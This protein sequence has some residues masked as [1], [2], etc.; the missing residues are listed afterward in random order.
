MRFDQWVIIHSITPVLLDNRNQLHVFEEPMVPLKLTDWISISSMIRWSFVMQELPNWRK[1]FHEYK[2]NAAHQFM[3]A[4]YCWIYGVKFCLSA[5][6]CRLMSLEKRQGCLSVRTEGTR[7]QRC[8]YDQ[9]PIVPPCKWNSTEF[10]ENF[11]FQLC[12]NSISGQ[13]GSSQ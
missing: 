4:E 7:F 10:K 13:D 3:M 8:Y 6:Y 2:T 9:V 12:G 11:P 1:A 5:S